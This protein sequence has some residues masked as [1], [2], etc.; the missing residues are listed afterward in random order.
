MKKLEA[1]ITCKN[2]EKIFKIKVED[3]KP[4]TSH[5]CPY[6]EAVYEIK[7]DDVS[8][9]QKKLDDIRNRFKRLLK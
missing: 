7:G 6:C 8:G 9:T 1:S 4:G 5:T 3:M 2:C